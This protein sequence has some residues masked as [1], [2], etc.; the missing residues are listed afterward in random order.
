[1]RIQFTR[2]FGATEAGAE[3]DDVM[4]AGGQAISA[5][6]LVHDTIDEAARLGRPGEIA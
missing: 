6:Y 1:M 5:G 3:V 4:R 2:P